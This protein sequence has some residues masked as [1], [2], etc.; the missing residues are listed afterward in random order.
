MRAKPTTGCAS[1]SGVMEIRWGTVELSA[2]W[3]VKE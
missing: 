3:N 2:P 1:L